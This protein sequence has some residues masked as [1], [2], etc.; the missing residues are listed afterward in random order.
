VATDWWQ[1]EKQSKA[2]TLGG[3]ILMRRG[4]PVNLRDQTH[5]NRQWDELR[6]W[7]HL[8]HGAGVLHTDL[9]LSNVVDFGDHGVQPVD[10]GMS[11]LLSRNTE[12]K[13]E[14][15]TN[16]ELGR[17]SRAEQAGQRIRALVDTAKREQG[18]NDF[19][20]RVAW[21]QA[22]D[23]DMLVDMGLRASW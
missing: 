11:V 2:T 8:Y 22:D 3:V 12:S 1:L 6:S 14:E 17:G 10:F 5:R 20:L 15:A 23:W 13:S 19:R 7:L 4:Q 18:S 21:T 9:R 16:V